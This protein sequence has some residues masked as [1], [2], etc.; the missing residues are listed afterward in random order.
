MQWQRHAQKKKNDGL[1]ATTGAAAAG[2]ATGAAAGAAG[3]TAAAPLR[4]S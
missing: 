1:P 3:V 4:G 2:A